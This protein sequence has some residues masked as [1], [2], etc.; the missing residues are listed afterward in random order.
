MAMRGERGVTKEKGRGVGWRQDF[1]TELNG[2]SRSTSDKG[3]SL[4]DS[5]GLVVPVK[6]GF[7]L[8]CLLYSVQYKT[9]FS[10]LVTF[11]LDLSPP[12]SKL[13]R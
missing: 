8:P 9:G 13:G 2:D 12:P 4:V 3:P 10:L 1:E 11:T 7:V 6:E 5:L